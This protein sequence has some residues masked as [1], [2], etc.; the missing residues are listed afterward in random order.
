MEKPLEVRAEY[1]IFSR[2]FEIFIH[3]GESYC[4]DLTM[5]TTDTAQPHAATP[6]R[7]CD[8]EAQQLMDDLYRA[9]VRPSEGQ[10]S[11]GQLSATQAHLADMRK[12]ASH[13]LKVEL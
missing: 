11:A 1:S 7:L 4:C 12:I 3:Q 2:T 13:K 10:G 8:T 9:G 5:R 6:V